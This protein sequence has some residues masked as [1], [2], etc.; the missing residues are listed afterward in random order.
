[1]KIVLDL[2][3]INWRITKF[4]LKYKEDENKNPYK[5][6]KKFIKECLKING[7]TIQFFPD[8]VNNIILIN[9][10]FRF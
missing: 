3:K 5:N 7:E 6:N 1:M 10:I 2:I 9:I 4:A 8:E